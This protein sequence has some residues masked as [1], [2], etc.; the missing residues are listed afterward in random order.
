MGS[1]WNMQLLYE[2]GDNLVQSHAAHGD[3]SR[4]ATT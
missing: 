1:N 2:D 3:N 4:A